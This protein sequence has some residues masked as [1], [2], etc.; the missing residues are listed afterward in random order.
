MTPYEQAQKYVAA[1]PGAVSGSGGHNQTYSVAV[2]LVHG[3]QLAD[4]DALAILHEYNSRCQPPWTEHDILHKITDARSVPH[5]KPAGHL[6]SKRGGK[7]TPYTPR[8]VTARPAPAPAPAKRVYELNPDT[9][10]PD[11]LPDGA[12]ALIRAA[13]KEGECVRICHAT[14]NEEGKEVPRD[15]GV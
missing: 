6:L 7:A 3:F 12:R 15:D 1:I 9:K 14:T 8:P 11:P 2:A 13:F 10:L 4:S 5:D